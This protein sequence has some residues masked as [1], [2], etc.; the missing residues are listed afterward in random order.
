MEDI[1]L[2][3][4]PEVTVTEKSVELDTDMQYELLHNDVVVDE[5]D[6]EEEVRKQ[7]QERDY[8]EEEREMQEE[9]AAHEREQ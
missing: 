1:Q 6:V 4:E 3:E 2:D 7:L 5:A 9:A 8:A